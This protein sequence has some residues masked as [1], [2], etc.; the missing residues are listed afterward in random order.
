M[1][2]YRFLRKNETGLLKDFLYEAI[3]IPEGMPLP[4]KS[5]IEKPKLSLYYQD[6]GSGKADNCIVAEKDNKVIGA[7]WS[8]I[9]ND[10]GHIDDDIPS[11][12][13]SL[14]K[15]YRGQGIGTNLMKQMLKLL[16]YQGYEK[17]SLAVQ[18][19]NY[20]V[21]MYRKLGFKISDENDQE[22]IMVCDL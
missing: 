21:I 15:Q 19:E 12:A 14:L 17:A 10:Y 9:M 7:I 3:Y 8:R 16:K 2:V 4:D 1:I 20:A 11:L 13:I 18:K 22:Y 5:I 6:F